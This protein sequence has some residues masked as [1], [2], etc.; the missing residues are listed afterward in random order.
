MRS[1]GIAFLVVCA[2]TT[3]TAQQQESVELFDHGARP[4]TDSGISFGSLSPNGREYFATVHGKDWRLHRIVVSRRDNAGKW[5]SRET[6][7]FSGKWN[8]REPK[9]SPD[10]RRL[11]FSSNRPLNGGSTTPRS[12]LD[13]WMAERDST[14]RW[15]V[16]RHVDAPLN[17][18]AND[19]SPVITG[20]GAMYFVST[21]PGG[22]GPGGTARIHNVWRAAPADRTGLHFAEPVNAG[23]AINAGF[24]TN[25]FVT[26]DER[27]ML[28]SRDGAPDGL[29]GDDLYVSSFVDGAWQPMRHLPA[30]INTDKYEYGPS[31][32]ADG[33][34]ILFTSMRANDGDTYRIPIAA[35]ERAAVERAVRDY[36]EGFYEG[37]TGKIARSLRPELDKLGFWKARDSV[38]YAS[39]KMTFEEALA[40]ARRFKAN[41]RTTPGDA[42]R[43][44]IIFDVLDQTASAKVRAWWGT[45]YLLL[46]KYNGRWQIV[47]VL[48]QG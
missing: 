42:P 23:G 30:P 20:N 31:I 13:I 25:V 19:F 39:E 8:D 22:I 3:A 10:G 9:L 48:W 45:D 46:A 2:A 11:Y 37:D 21:R 44:V 40:Y 4:P 36:L 38:T 34:W 1:F 15:S 26:P 12:D 14:G 18:T 47:Q 29:G 28:V 17:G 5:S 43:E 6:L 24:E 41:N 7:P 32:T 27:T 16:P 33:K 35:I